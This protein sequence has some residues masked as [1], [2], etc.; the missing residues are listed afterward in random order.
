[1]REPRILKI[2]LTTDEAAS[3]VKPAALKASRPAEFFLGFALEAFPVRLGSRAMNEH[4]LRWKESIVKLRFTIELL[5]HIALGLRGTSLGWSARG[6]ALL[7]SG[8]FYRSKATAKTIVIT[9]K[10]NHLAFVSEDKHGSQK[11]IHIGLYHKSGRE[12]RGIV[13]FMKA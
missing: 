12:G 3:M 13:K 2:E 9:S 11:K 4:L 1:M 8:C 6:L 10:T 7:V 5:A